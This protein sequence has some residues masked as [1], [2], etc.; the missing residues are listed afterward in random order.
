MGRSCTETWI[1]PL[2]P[3]YRSRVWGGGRFPP[4]Q[5]GPTGEVWLA[6]QDNR[7]QSG[8][9][10]GRT[11]AGAL[12]ELGPAFLGETAYRR[13]GLE[14]P[15]LIKI[16]DTAEWL[17][18]QVHPDDAYAHT[19]EA[20]T[21]Y[22][23]K[24]EAWYILEAGPG[25][26]IVYGLS[27]PLSKEALSETLRTGQAFS[28]L[29]RVPVRAGQT[30]YVPA[31][32]VHA[33][34]PGLLLYEVQQRSDLTYRLYDFGRGRPLHLEKGLEV[35]HLQPR[36]LPAATD[37]GALVDSSWFSLRRL[38]LDNR[39]TLRAPDDSF[40]VFTRLDAAEVFPTLLVGAGSCFSAEA[41]V[42]LAAT[43][44]RGN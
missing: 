13:Y 32:T 1:L 4:T 19:M 29:R 35:A 21:G 20:H 14:L 11:V 44:K 12:A 24:N 27:R 15:L 23:G 9:L 28:V 8:P 2:E 16:I 41:G 17:S 33:L 5:N 6:Y 18:V 39:D 22:H 36:H 40:A 30:I 31:G 7:V 10:A 42:W 43:P 37:S 3:L 34:G 26:E 25:A 38:V